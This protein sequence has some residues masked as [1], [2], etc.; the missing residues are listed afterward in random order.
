MSDSEV[1]SRIPSDP[2]MRRSHWKVWLALGVA[3][4]GPMAG[5]HGFEVYFPVGVFLAAGTFRADSVS[6]GLTNLA[7]GGFFLLTYFVITFLLITGVAI[8]YRVL[9][10]L[11]APRLPGSG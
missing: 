9:R 5:R 3:A 1:S 8:L 7:F 4:L 2:S 6:E 10:H 11:P